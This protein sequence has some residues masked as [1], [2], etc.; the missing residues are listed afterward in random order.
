MLENV[1]ARDRGLEIMKII[2][3][4]EDIFERYTEDQ[5]AKREEENRDKNLKDEE[6]WWRNS[7]WGFPWTTAIDE[8]YKRG[9]DPNITQGVLM[10]LIRNGILRNV[11][12][13]SSAEY[14]LNY[15]EDVIA[16]VGRYDEKPDLLTTT[17]I[18]SKAII[19]EV[20]EIN[21]NDVL[22]DTYLKD[23]L[24]YNL[25]ET[26]KFGNKI[27]IKLIADYFKEMF[28][29]ILYF[30]SLLALIHQY[31]ISDTDVLTPNNGKVV[32]H[33]GFNLAMFGTPGTGKTFSIH[34]I[35]CEIGRASCRERV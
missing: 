12:S 20:A 4:L 15:K 14:R 5:I 7:R 23:I 29:D 35:I 32:S 18:A 6:K 26:I 17:N 10:S 30:D 1:L 2:L 22:F 9:V 8:C 28:G 16:E 24:D 13:N 31:A 3:E 21:R 19:A 11:G 27:D 34:D 25:E 33:I